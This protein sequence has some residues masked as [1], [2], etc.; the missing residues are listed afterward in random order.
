MPLVSNRKNNFLFAV[1]VCLSSLSFLC[2]LLTYIYTEELKTE[3]FF[4]LLLYIGTVLY[5]IVKFGLLSLY[6]IY[7]YTSAFFIYD[8]LF[9]ILITDKSFLVINYP[10]TYSFDESVGFIFIN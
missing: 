9:M 1:Y 7:L 5:S 6:S 10:R 4:F 2:G 3:I 8:C